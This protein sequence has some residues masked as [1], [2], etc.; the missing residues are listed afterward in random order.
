MGEEIL[1]FTD[2]KERI[3]REEHIREEQISEDTIK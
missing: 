2:D 1:K 3:I